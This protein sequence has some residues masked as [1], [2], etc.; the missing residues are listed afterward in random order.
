MNIEELSKNSGDLDIY[1]Y[2]HKNKHI[3]VVWSGGCDSTKALYSILNQL[4]N[5]EDTR[6]VI[7]YSFKHWQVSDVK[8]AK[9]SEARSNF[10]KYCK[11]KDLPLGICN[12]IEIPKQTISIGRDAC[13]QAA[14]WL[15][16]VIPLIPDDSIVVCGYIK[17]DDFFNYDVF[18]N[19]AK[20]FIGLTN[21]YGKKAF[22]FFPLKYV[23]KEYVIEDLKRDDILKYTWHCE[24]PNFDGT[25]C[26]HCGPCI[27][28][29]MADLWLKDK[30]NAR[31]DLIKVTSVSGSNS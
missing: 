4:K 1:D 17:G 21:L 6:K 5:R 11:D 25:E 15:S 18:N 14:M 28:F 13:P 9:E 8:M 26:N 27:K 10:I 19:W 2:P 22:P 20:I 30:E 24:C 23:S 12:E 16:H 29:K 31:L 7:T 3:N